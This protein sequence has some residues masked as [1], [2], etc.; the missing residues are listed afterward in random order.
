MLTYENCVYFFYGDNLLQTDNELFLLLRD[1][2]MMAM[3]T[4]VDSVVGIVILL[5]NNGITSFQEYIFVPLHN[6]LLL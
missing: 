4:F 2:V 6:L 1:S 5:K 3:K